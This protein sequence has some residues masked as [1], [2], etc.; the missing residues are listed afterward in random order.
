M[1]PMGLGGRRKTEKCEHKAEKG[2][3]REGYS[4]SV[5][6]F[7]RGPTHRT[8]LG[9]S[10]GSVGRLTQLTI[11]LIGRIVHFAKPNLL[12]RPNLLSKNE[13]RG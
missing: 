5:G 3:K 7:P 4:H 11:P 13:L 8:C 2:E 12:R 9:G 10:S 6:T 1:I